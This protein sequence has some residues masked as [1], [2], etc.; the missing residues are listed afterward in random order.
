[1]DTWYDQAGSN[2]ATQATQ[3]SQPQIH[4]GTVNTDLITQNGKPMLSTNGAGF[5]VNFN[6]VQAFTVV[7]VGKVS[8]NNA[9]LYSDAT[10]TYNMRPFSGGC[11]G[12]SGSTL[13]T[14]GTYVH[15]GQLWTAYIA[16]GASSYLEA[17]SSAGSESK[18][19]NSGS[20]D[21]TVST[22]TNR[23]VFDRNYDT[24]EVIFWN[25]NQGTTNIAAIET[26]MDTYYSFS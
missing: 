15:S 3:G 17:T 18:T 7:S 20:V 21:F 6:L 13:I 22:L 10:R 25:V 19:G 14:N 11:Q 1:V 4:D 26:E 24:Q 2:D 12:R 23:N 5:T 16:N 8:G 9:H